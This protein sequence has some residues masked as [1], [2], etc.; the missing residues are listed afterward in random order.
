MSGWS[1]GL[2]VSGLLPPLLVR[3]LVIAKLSSETGCTDF[4][5]S[6]HRSDL[7]VV[8]LDHWKGLQMWHPIP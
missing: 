3:R 5:T 2:L 8:M 1:I 6:A 7:G 4:L